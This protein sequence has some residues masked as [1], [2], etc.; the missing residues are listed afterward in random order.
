MQI[1]IKKKSMVLKQIFSNVI[2]HTEYTAKENYRILFTHLIVNG[3]C[4]FT[5]KYVKHP[6]FKCQ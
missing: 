1:I 6:R 3:Q 4:P 5:T 2:Q